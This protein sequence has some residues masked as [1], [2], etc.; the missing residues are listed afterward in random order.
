MRRSLAAAALVAFAF[1]LG[2]GE[3]RSQSINLADRVEEDWVLVADET[4]SPDGPQV[5]TVMGPTSDLSQPVV[6]LNINYR[7]S[8]GYLPGGLQAIVYGSYGLI[9]SKVLATDALNL[10]NET[11]SWTQRM[12]ISGGTVRYLIPSVSST[13]WGTFT[14]S[15]ELASFATTNATLKDYSPDASAANSGGAWKTQGLK[16]LTLVA[17]RYYVAGVLIQTDTTARPVDFTKPF[18][19]P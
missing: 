2:S 19:R 3:S 14:D 10:A 5:N 13:S 1:G 16:S 17:V 6:A 18:T 4:A 11:V 15:V 9:S 7:Q 8:P 12:T